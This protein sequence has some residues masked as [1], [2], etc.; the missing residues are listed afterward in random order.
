MMSFLMCAMAWVN[1]SMTHAQE[2][3]IWS[4]EASGVSRSYK[5]EQ[6]SRADD[7]WDLIIYNAPNFDKSQY[8]ET[9]QIFV[10]SLLARELTGKGKTARGTTI[11]VRAFGGTVAFQ[12]EEASFGAA[13]GRCVRHVELN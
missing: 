13:C 2:R 10:D 11:T 8:A 4:C 6:L 9:V 1:I 7:S 3:I 5:V 12:V